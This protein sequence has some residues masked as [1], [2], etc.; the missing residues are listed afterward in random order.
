MYHGTALQLVSVATLPRRARHQNADPA[1]RQTRRADQQ[2]TIT[3]KDFLLLS[4]GTKSANEQ[5]LG[6][7]GGAPQASDGRAGGRFLLSAWSLS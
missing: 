2:N 6:S 3:E 4:A 5:S 1:G 7:T